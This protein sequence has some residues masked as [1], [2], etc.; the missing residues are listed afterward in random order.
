MFQQWGAE[1]W[2][3]R[4]PA[5]YRSKRSWIHAKHR[6][7]SFPGAQE[8]QPKF[9]EERRRIA[10]E[11]IQVERNYFGQVQARGSVLQALF[12]R[13]L[14]GLLHHIQE[15]SFERKR[16]VTPFLIETFTHENPTFA[17]FLLKL[18]LYTS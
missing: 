2:R 10:A 11:Q 6:A 16:S 17:D 1:Q 7:F 15:E 9:G 8:Q 4:H 18:I 12:E 14:A 3:P 5:G 13:L